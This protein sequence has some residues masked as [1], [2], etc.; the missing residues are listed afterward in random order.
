MDFRFIV[1]VVVEKEMKSEID[2]KTRVLIADDL[3]SVRSALRLVLEQEPEIA[4]TGEAGD[5]QELV[6][7]MAGGC[8]DIVLLDW[9]L[10]GAEG[11]GLLTQIKEKCPEMVVITLSS[12]P[13]A[14]KEALKA[15]ADGFISKG[16]PPQE[17]V[18]AVKKYLPGEK[19]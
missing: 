1:K 17:V 18:A 14:R 3:L 10:P 2:S 19:S 8:P 7:R 4:V 11:R 9:E 15:G 16:N 6:E 5:F 12:L 13:D